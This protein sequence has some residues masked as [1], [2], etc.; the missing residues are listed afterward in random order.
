MKNRFRPCSVSSLCVY[1]AA[2][3]V[4]VHQRHLSDRSSVAFEVTLSATSYI[5]MIQIMESKRPGRQLGRST[6]S[7]LHWVF[8]WLRN[9]PRV[10]SDYSKWAH[11]CPWVSTLIGLGTFHDQLHISFWK[12]MARLI[13]QKI[14]KRGLWQRMGIHSSWRS[15]I[16]II[17]WLGEPSQT[18][19]G[20]ASHIIFGGTAGGKRRPQQSLFRQQ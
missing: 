9:D 7:S 4:A 15:C 3:R 17:Y 13:G 18:F 19:H 14:Q 2:S 16:P 12:R 5:Q 1:S 6:H 8:S 10:S 11:E 20:C